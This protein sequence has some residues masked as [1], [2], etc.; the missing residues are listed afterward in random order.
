MQEEIEKLL[1]MPSHPSMETSVSEAV[2]AGTSEVVCGSADEHIRNKNGTLLVQVTDVFTGGEY[3]EHS[4]QIL[5]QQWHQK[6]RGK[7]TRKKIESCLNEAKRRIDEALR[8]LRDESDNEVI[9][10][11]ENASEAVECFVIAD[12]KVAFQDGD[13]EE[14]DLSSEILT[15]EEVEKFM[16]L[17]KE[18]IERIK[19]MMEMKVPDICVSL[20]KD[21][22]ADIETL[23]TF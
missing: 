19:S 17:T 21:E 8:I 5:A 10:D 4:F 14:F 23:D 3:A 11:V 9:S 16:I 13:A 20:P 15:D 12:P 2:E 22:C 6:E 7:K 18:E 1:L